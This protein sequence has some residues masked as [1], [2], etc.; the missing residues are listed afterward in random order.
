MSGSSPTGPQPWVLA[1]ALAGDHLTA[2]NA[3]L[4]GRHNGTVV[5]VAPSLNRFGSGFCLVSYLGTNQIYTWGAM[6]LETL[7]GPAMVYETEA[8]SLAL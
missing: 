8:H 4:I 2:P 6:G 3:G 1:L 5:G 7:S